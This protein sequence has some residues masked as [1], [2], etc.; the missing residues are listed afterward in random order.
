MTCRIEGLDCDESGTKRGEHQTAI[1]RK[2]FDGLRPSAYVRF[3]YAKRR[4]TGWRYIKRCGRGRAI[5]RAYVWSGWRYV[6][7]SKLMIENGDV[8]KGSKWND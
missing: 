3:R 1:A 5:V 7:Y 4:D 2:Y 8:K 6:D